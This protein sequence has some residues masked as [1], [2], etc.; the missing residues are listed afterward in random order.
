MGFV[1]CGEEKRPRVNLHHSRATTH[2]R[3]CN[4]LSSLEIVSHCYLSN[5][6]AKCWCAK[7]SR[8]H[9]RCAV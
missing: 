6:L 4:K 1:D 2:K 5:S 8:S 9:F 7:K 3:R